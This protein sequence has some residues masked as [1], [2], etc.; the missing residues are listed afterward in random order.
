MGFSLFGLSGKDL[1]IGGVTAAFSMIP[2]AGVVLGPLAGAATS[3]IW[4]KAEGKDWDEAIEGGLVD[5]LLGALP[6]GKLAGGALRT[7]AKGGAGKVAKLGLQKG[8][9]KI[10][11]GGA[12]GSA[13]AA[14]TKGAA[15]TWG[16]RSV[17]ALG[18]GL[19]AAYMNKLYDSMTASS[20]PG[21]DELP[22]RLIS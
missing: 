9:A 19:G 4:S 15:T 1:A 6:G 18:R 22:I 17:K 21:I 7:L 14:I 13:K 20:T 8:A 2:G 11:Y 10:L 5:G 12:K 3:A 16:E